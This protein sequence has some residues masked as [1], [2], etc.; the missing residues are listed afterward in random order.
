MPTE[1]IS[2]VV[3]ERIRASVRANPGAP[4]ARTVQL[5]LD[6]IDRL[7]SPEYLPQRLATWEPDVECPLTRR[8]LEIIIRTANGETS[9]H[10]GVELGIESAS[11]RGHRQAI[12]RRL[13]VP[14]TTV[15]V[16]VSLLNGWIPTGVLT[17]PEFPRCT[18]TVIAR[19]TYRQRAAALRQTPG[20]WGTV[21]S[22]TGRHAA[23]QAAYRIRTGKFAA[24]QPRGHWDAA[25]FAAPDSTWCVRAR[26]V[27]TPTSTQ[28]AAS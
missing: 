5:L 20:E 8:Q 15:A 24:F 23:K 22:Y 13:G 18:P 14:S 26:Y 27:E 10:I 6:E 16:A 28:K 21:A 4:A 3:L 25:L 19:K 9:E 12:M 7:N 17:L 1:P 2:H 11:V